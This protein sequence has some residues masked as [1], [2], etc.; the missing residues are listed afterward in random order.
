MIHWDCCRIVP[1]PLGEPADDQKSDCTPP[2]AHGCELF[3]LAAASQMSG[4]NGGGCIEKLQCPLLLPLLL[5][6][7]TSSLLSSKSPNPS[8]NTQYGLYSSNPRWPRG[9]AQPGLRCCAPASPRWLSGWSLPPG[10][11]RRIM[12]ACHFRQP[13]S[14]LHRHRR[15]Q[16]PTKQDLGDHPHVYTPPQLQLHPHPGQALP[17]AMVS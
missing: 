10:G 4:K 13:R 7:F 3:F 16:S 14:E 5:H 17:L 11:R 6:R 12:E 9:H 8:S 2:H 15:S 1:E